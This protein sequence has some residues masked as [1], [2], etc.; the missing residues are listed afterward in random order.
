MANKLHKELGVPEEFIDDL[1]ATYGVGTVKS[2]VASGQNKNAV[3]KN[4]DKRTAPAARAFG[5]GEARKPLN[6]YAW[7]SACADNQEF[8][9]YGRLTTAKAPKR[10]ARIVR[11]L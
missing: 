7:L 8:A 2:W 3:N 6:W 11:D 10:M 4:I 9:G 1:Y 5:N